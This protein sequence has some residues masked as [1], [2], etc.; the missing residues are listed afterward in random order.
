MT[1]IPVRKL[2]KLHRKAFV[3]FYY[4]PCILW[5]ILKEIKTVEQVKKI[6]IRI[7]NIYQ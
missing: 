7:L 2:R 5:G 4:R 1:D 6:I 3:G